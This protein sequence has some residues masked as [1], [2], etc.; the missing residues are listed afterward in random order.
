MS[1]KHKWREDY[2]KHGFRKKDGTERLQCILC[3][4][5]FSNANLKPSRLKEHLDSHL[6]GAKSGNDFN[7]LKIKMARFH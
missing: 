2:V 5:V 7:T 3:N 4:K 1:I 6:G